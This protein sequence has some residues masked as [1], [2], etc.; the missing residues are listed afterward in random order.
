MRRRVAVSLLAVACGPTP[1]TTPPSQAPAPAPIVASPEPTAP[2]VAQADP[3]A[4]LSA[5]EQRLSEEDFHFVF[6]VTSSGVVES[7]LNGEVWARGNHLQMSATGTFAG[8][9]ID[10]RLSADGERMRATVGGKTTV[11]MPQPED[12]KR[13]IVV[14]LTRM[15]VLHNIAVMLG[16]R[17]PDHADGGVDEWVVADAF[18]TQPKVEPSELTADSVGGA[19][20][21]FDLTVAGKPAGE[22][23]L[24]LDP[25]GGRPLERHQAVE[26][27]EGSMTVREVY[28]TP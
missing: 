19:L 20:V 1:A 16:G 12:L 11:D 3:R 27:P 17:P 4:Q 6:T 2:V 18:T 21:S 5:L 13:A 9:P 26:F 24:W 25:E 14:G 28:R 8:T 15:G 22:V 7:G 23:S 10:V